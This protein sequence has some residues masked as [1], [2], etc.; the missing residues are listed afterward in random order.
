MENAN[1]HKIE[2][3][4]HKKKKKNYISPATRE[5]HTRESTKGTVN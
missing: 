2:I 3:A 4:A 5:L 1:I